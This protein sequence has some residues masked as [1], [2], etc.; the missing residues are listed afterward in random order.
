[1]AIDM[2]TTKGFCRARIN[3]EMTIYT[4]AEYRNEIL[5]LCHTRKGMELDLEQVSEIDITGVQL[6][7]ALKKH[8]DQTESGLQLKNISPEVKETLE[9]IRLGGVFN[10]QQEEQEGVS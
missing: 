4:A 3:G 5:E 7:L 6:L 8:L 2:I 1:M 10:M 9:M